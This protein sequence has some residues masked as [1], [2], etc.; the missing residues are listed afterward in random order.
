MLTFFLTEVDKNKEPLSLLDVD[1]PVL[2]MREFGDV[3][4][5]HHTNG[6]VF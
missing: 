4:E 2:V 6:R 5:F 1:G 3:V